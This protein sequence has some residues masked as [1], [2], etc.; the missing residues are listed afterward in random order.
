[1]DEEGLEKFLGWIPG[2]FVVGEGVR[3]LPRN[4]DCMRREMDGREFWIA[5]GPW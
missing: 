3:A 4:A 5:I 2:S 1:M